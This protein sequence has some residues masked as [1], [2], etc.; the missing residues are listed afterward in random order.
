[1]SIVRKIAITLLAFVIVFAGLGLSARPA[2]AASCAQYYWVRYG[3]SLSGIAAYYGVSTSY[4]RQ[5]NNVSPNRLYAG[6]RICVRESGYWP[7]RNYPYNPY[8][9]Y[10]PYYG[11]GTGGA[12][13][14]VNPL[15]GAYGELKINEIKK[16]VSVTITTGAMPANETMQVWIGSVKGQGSDG[17]LVDTF[18]SGTGASVTKTYSIPSSP[19]EKNLTEARRIGVRLQ[20]TSSSF[21]S[22]NWFTQEATGGAYQGGGDGYNNPYCYYTWNGYYNY[23]RCYTVPTF[24]IQSVSRNNSVRIRTY[25]FPPNVNFNVLMNYSGTRGING[26]YVQT[27]NSGAGG[28]FEATFSIPPALYGQY[29]IAIRL[30]SPGTGYYAYNWF[31]NG[32]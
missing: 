6:Q 10:Y 8:Y 2:Q 18:N 9:Y 32:W 26:Y 17:S 7:W 25:N 3:D 4:L 11:Y 16:G 14:R 31:N 13:Q 15:P 29:Q 19:E 5:I 24:S 27:I 12:Y 1:M 30:E 21:Y 20:S 28:S 23:Y 22:F